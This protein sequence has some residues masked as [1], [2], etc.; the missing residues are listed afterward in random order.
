MTVFRFPPSVS[1][2]QCTVYVLI[3]LLQRHIASDIDRNKSASGYRH[4]VFCKGT[5]RFK[6]AV[7]VETHLDNTCVGVGTLFVSWDDLRSLVSVI[8]LVI[9]DS[10]LLERNGIPEMEVT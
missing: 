9:R 5:R 1:F 10:G 7:S 3:R 2:Y 4:V 8:S 6:T